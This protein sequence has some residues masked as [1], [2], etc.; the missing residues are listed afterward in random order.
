MNPE[1]MTPVLEPGRNR[2]STGFSSEALSACAAALGWM[3]SAG[4]RMLEIGVYPRLSAAEL[5]SRLS[6]AG[7]LKS[8]FICVYLRLVLICVYLRL[9]NVPLSA[10]GLLKAGASG[11]P[12]A[13]AR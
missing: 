11:I 5:N 4:R 8:V 1:W 13:G 10:A 2:K 12:L 7:F 9:R 6:A 3:A